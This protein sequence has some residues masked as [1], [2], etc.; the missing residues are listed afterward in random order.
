MVRKQRVPFIVA[1]GALVAIAACNKG[2]GGA[3]TSESQG[4]VVAR[5][6]GRPI[7][8]SYYEQR[9]AKMERRFLPDTLDL[10]GRK[11]FLDFIVNKELM[12]LKA[13]ELK[14]DEDP[15]ITNSIRLYEDNLAANAAIDRL[16]D[17]KLTVTQAESDA[18]HGQKKRVV[19]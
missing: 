15:R 16:C 6:G 9:L 1:C 3:K 17:G 5:V 10:A 4:E 19:V 2:G 11:Q 18:F 13:E 8:K 12:A 7:T 14:Y